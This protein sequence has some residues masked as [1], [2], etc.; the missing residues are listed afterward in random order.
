MLKYDS[1]FCLGYFKHFCYETSKVYHQVIYR[2]H[3]LVMFTVILKILHIKAV[4]SCSYQGCIKA[5]ARAVDLF[6]I[7]NSIFTQV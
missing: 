2:N 3:A 1:G 6:S 7:Q 4:E 5:V